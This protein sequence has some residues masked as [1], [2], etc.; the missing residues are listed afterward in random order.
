[1]RLAAVVF[2]IA[3]LLPQDWPPRHP[4][5]G[6]AAGSWVE[7]AQS[8]GNKVSNVWRLRREDL[9]RELPGLAALETGLVLTGRHDD[10]LVLQDRRLDCDVLQY[11]G[12]DDEPSRWVSLTVW[13]ARGVS[14]PPRDIWRSPDIGVPSDVVKLL[15]CELR[16][17][18]MTALALDVVDLR[19]KITVNG[20]A[21]DSSLED[22]LTIVAATDRPTGI[23]GRR[24]WICDAIPGRVA[25]RDEACIYGDGG[26]YYTVEVTDFKAVR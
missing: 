16:G 2:L 14:L 8:R 5:D 17:D 19:R 18:R 1:V 20:S 22:V 15:R 7:C 12:P 4:W 10:T 21:L 23:R 11:S 9:S 3:P 25:R 26:G 24:R 6:F 13:K